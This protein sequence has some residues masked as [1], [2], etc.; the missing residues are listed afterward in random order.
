[1]SPKTEIGRSAVRPACPTLVFGLRF[2]R[3]AF[4]R[5]PAATVG[6]RFVW[7][8]GPLLLFACCSA[9]AQAG[10]GSIR[11]TTLESWNGQP[12]AGVAVSLRG[13]TLAVTTDA[14]GR[15]E[16]S[17]VPP[18]LH[19][20]QFS[21]PGYARA[22]VT[23]VLVAPGQASQVNI[24]L[25]PEFYELEEY[26]V[27]APE[28]EQQEQELLVERQSV[29]ALI[30]AIGTERFS[31]LAAGDAAEI[32]TKIT[33][34][35]VVE[36]KFAVIR[37]LSDRY[38]LA[39]LNGAD[40]PSADPYRRAVQLD[41]FPAEVIQNV[42]VSKTFTPDLPGG[43]SGGVMDIRT[44]S[45]PERFLFKI[46]AG[47]GYNTQA[48][49]NERF[50]A[51]PGGGTDFLALDDGTRAMPG[52]LEDVSGDDL[53]RLLSTATSGSQNIPLAEKTA[54]AARM[55]RLV[56]SFGTPFMGPDR[57][58]PPDHDFSL[59]V[60]DTV[61]LKE[62]PLGWFANLSYEHDYRFYEDGIRRRY[63]PAGGEPEIYQDYQ[64]SRSASVAQWSALASLASRFFE[65]HELGYTFLYAQNAEDTARKL[66]GQI[67][68]SGEDQFNDARR[69]HLNELHWT[70]RNLTAHQFRGAHVIP[71]LNDL[72]A[73]WLISF[74]NTSQLEPD[75]R[76]FNFISYPNPQNPDD[77][78]RGVDLISNNTPFPERPTRY[79]RALEDQNLNA[80][81]DL[82]LPGEDW[83]GLPWKVKS[84]VWGSQSDRA[85]TERTFSYAGGNGSL[86]DIE[87]FPYE[88]MLGTNAPPPRLVTQNNRSRYVFARSLNSTFGNNYY[89]GLQ[90]IYAV[91]GMAEIPVAPRV[92][93]TGGAR[94]ETTLLE[95]SSSAFQS[96]QTF[97][98]TIDEGDALPAVNLSWELRDQMNVR[99]SYAE[100]VAR[101]TYRE[102]ARYRSFDVTGD[103]IVEGNPFLKMTHIRNLDARWEW[104][105]PGGGLL[106]AG[107]FYKIL[108]DPIEKFN[109]TLSPDGTPIWTASSDF[110]T[111]LNTPEATV[112]GVE[113]EARQNLAFLEPNLRPFSFGLNAAWI[114]TEVALQ[115]EIQEMKF[116][117]TGEWF[118]TRPLYD[119]SP[120]ILNADLSYDNERMGT[121][122]TLACYYAAERLALIV[123]N[124]WDIYEQAA[125]SLDLVISQRL[126]KGLK[127]K[128]TARNLLDPKILRTY[129]VGG[130]TDREFIYSSHNRGVTFGLSLS[131][132][133]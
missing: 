91:Y 59:L 15:F 131:Y 108:E 107:A 94:Y 2:I 22:I 129:A 47:V 130:P 95:V 39:L 126:A 54:A 13:T 26:V 62:I 55:D 40:V 79:F 120:Y 113:F 123:N 65:R 6:L 37:G 124:G 74:A 21:K 106:S 36:G 112:W 17:P 100:T 57:E 127:A 30:E 118:N 73:D 52:E 103:Q 117:A 18:G 8:A 16:L 27:T 60:G 104:F 69:T 58:A 97:T 101:P 90:D 42:S 41:L 75:L 92:R 76:Y 43:F 84:G 86:V 14:Q 102:F 49:G 80:K 51:Y 56:R 77:P 83:R 110:V 98:G 128:F 78:L 63:R 119:Q 48:T 96:A 11:G 50:L 29:S 4:P 46:N 1:L 12:L 45:F 3:L 105:T 89:D 87:T 122:V 99:L 64:D 67:E 33:G 20:V 88:Y 38:N 133:Y 121:S 23:E 66:T 35:S 72:A 71:P 31:R 68:S 10:A 116:Q 70:E 109:A 7:L 85:F 32:M 82:T 19:T 25:R 24:S 61:K 115:P 114:D 81:L 28:L 44:K 5:W 53:Q 111:F 132:E 9:R 125:P 34:V 93:L